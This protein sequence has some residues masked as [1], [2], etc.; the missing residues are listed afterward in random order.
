[1][2]YERCSLS[3]TLSALAEVESP[4]HKQSGETPLP[5]YA[6]RTSRLMEALCSI[7]FAAGGEG[8]ARLAYAQGLPASPRT[9]LRLLHAYPLPEAPPARVV[10]I[11]EW[12]W[13][14][15]K[16]YGTILVDLER[17]HPIDLL[18]DR[19][20]DRVKTWFE[21]H[22]GVEI[23]VRDRSG[24]FADGARRG[25]PAAMQVVD[26]YHLIVRHLT[27]CDMADYRPRIGVTF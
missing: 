20:A 4:G 14:K 27:W 25:E 24:L 16:S 18:S 6:R 23:I 21:Q 26:R 5:A 22:P 9:L 12:A 3:L 11:D 1:M 19:N 15:R 13:K 10:G 2:Q 7:A 17:K 8:G